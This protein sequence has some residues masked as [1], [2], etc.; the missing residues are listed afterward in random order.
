[1]PLARPGPGGGGLEGAGAPSPLMVERS[2][3]LKLRS[4]SDKAPCPW[5]QHR[6][7]PIRGLPHRPGTAVGDSDSQHSRDQAPGRTPHRAAAQRTCGKHRGGPGPECSRASY[8]LSQFLCLLTL[9][10]FRCPHNKAG[11]Q[12]DPGWRKRPLPSVP[13][14]QGLSV[15]SPALHK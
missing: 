11:P 13:T 5:T 2:C 6:G 7:T 14:L 1:M 4:R 12:P 9:L 15:A 8:R 10:S 3:M